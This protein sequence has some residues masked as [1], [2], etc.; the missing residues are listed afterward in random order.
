MT[1]ADIWRYLL[2][3]GKIRPKWWPEGSYVEMHGGYACNHLGQKMDMWGFSSP[4]D[5]LLLEEGK[6]V[7]AK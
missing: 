4:K 6:N 7:H 3:G 2:E 5:Y 1:Q